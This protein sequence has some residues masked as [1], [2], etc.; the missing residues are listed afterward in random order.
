[1]AEGNVFWLEQQVLFD[2]RRQL[3]G[4]NR[5]AFAC[6]EQIRHA[7]LGYKLGKRSSNEKVSKGKAP[8]F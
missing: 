3:I 4:M 6:D 5:A 7:A 8:D 2:E 1:M